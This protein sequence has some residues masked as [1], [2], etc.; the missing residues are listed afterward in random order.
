MAKGILY[1]HTQ[2]NR[3]VRQLRMM[4]LDLSKNP[5]TIIRLPLDKE[6][7][8]DIEDITPGK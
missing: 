2:H 8:Q 5:D 3:R 6:K 1:Y 7:R 4:E